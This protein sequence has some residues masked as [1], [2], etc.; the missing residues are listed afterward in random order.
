MQRGWSADSQRSTESSDIPKKSRSVVI[1]CCS[2]SDQALFGVSEFSSKQLK[3]GAWGTS[4]GCQGHPQLELPVNLTLRVALHVFD[5][6]PRFSQNSRFFLSIIVSL[7]LCLMFNWHNIST[8]IYSLLQFF[9]FVSCGR[10]HSLTSKRF[11]QQPRIQPRK[12]VVKAKISGKRQIKSGEQPEW[13][14]SLSVCRCLAQSPIQFVRSFCLSSAW[15]R[16][17]YEKQ[18]S[19][20]NLLWSL[21]QLKQCFL[22][23]SA[24]I[25]AIACLWEQIACIMAACLNFNKFDYNKH[26][27]QLQSIHLAACI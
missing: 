11:A 10:D 24:Q 17:C 2:W 21:E 9:H 27:K 13:L 4:T 22:H 3:V 18:G 14:V 25:T 19:F 6:R 8:Y 23:T 1:R 20:A 15:H 5:A 7:L 12:A 26:A 16:F